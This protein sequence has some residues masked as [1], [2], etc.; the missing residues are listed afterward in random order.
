MLRNDWVKVKVKVRV[1]V[2]VTSRLEVYSQS[3]HLGVSP[4]RPTT[5]DI[6]QL[7]T[8]GNSPYATMTGSP[9]MSS[10]KP[11]CTDRVE[12]SPSI[13][14]EVCLL[15]CCIA[16]FAARII[17]NS[18]LLLLRACILWALPNNCRCLQILLLETGLYATIRLKFENTEGLQKM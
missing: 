18:V 2:K 11:P 16:T 13:F 5:R 1:K 3:V 10:L 17:E 7:N 9:Q 4:L 14:V 8:C 6:F 15:R 12:N